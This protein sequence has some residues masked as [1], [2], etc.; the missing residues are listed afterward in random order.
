MTQ[1]VHEE[2]IVHYLTFSCY[3]KL[4]LFKGEPFYKLF[5]ESLK[6]ARSRHSFELW[7][8]VIMPNHVHL[9]LF[10]QAD[11][12][13]STLLASIKRPFAFKALRLL[14]EKFPDVYAQCH[15]QQGSRQITRFWQT[16]G[17]YDRHVYGPKAIRNY[18]DYIHDNPVRSG[19]V[20]LPEEWHWSSAR[21]WMNGEKE[22]IEIE[23]AE[24]S[25]NG[26]I[27]DL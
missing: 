1:L 3:N 7:A 18:I 21:F 24:R 4:W 19:L 20:A 10:P 11:T 9:L 2:G 17:G 22:P 6:T 16:G 25:K 5:I 26:G 14:E 23:Y 13:L 12:N 15:V 27:A 8:Y